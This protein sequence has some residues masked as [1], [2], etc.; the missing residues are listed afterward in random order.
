M[1]IFSLGLSRSQLLAHCQ[2]LDESP[3]VSWELIHRAYKAVSSYGLASRE[4]SYLKARLL[5]VQSPA[6]W[7][8]DFP[9]IVIYRFPNEELRYFLV[10]Q[11]GH[12]FESDAAT[13]WFPFFPFIHRKPNGSL[14]LDIDQYPSLEVDVNVAWLPQNPNYSH[15]LCDFFA[16]WL[17]FDLQL[18]AQEYN[19][20]CLQFQSFP[21]WQQPFLNCLNPSLHQLPLSKSSPLTIIKPRSVFLPLVSNVLLAQSILRSWLMQV[22]AGEYRTAT[23]LDPIPLILLGRS[24]YRQAR[25]RNYEEIQAYALEHD[26]IILDPSELTIS[27][28][29]RSLLPAQRII[30]EG[31]GSLNSVLFASDKSLTALL[32][33]AAAFCDPLMLDGGFPYLNSIAHRIRL[34]IGRNPTP[35]PGSPLGSCTYPVEKIDSCFSSHV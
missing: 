15:F 6:L 4:T 13:I 19:I 2:Y 25:V 10:S 8:L 7:R 32:M 16:P 17:P 11:D 35:I 22:Y 5:D 20:S 27:D 23:S 29:I 9:T 26:G 21:S 34:C 3:L 12:L 24:D 30:C 1:R 28:K 31:S 14:T 33:D 18:L